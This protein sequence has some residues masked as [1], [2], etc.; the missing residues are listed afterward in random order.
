[1]MTYSRN[2]HAHSKCSSFTIP[3]LE[4]L[5]N[6]LDISILKDQRNKFYNMASKALLCIK[7]LGVILFL[8]FCYFVYTLLTKQFVCL[9]SRFND[10]IK[11]M[12][13]HKPNFFWQA[14]W[15]VIS[16]LIMFLILVFYIITKVSEE[17]LYKVWDPESVNM[18][19]F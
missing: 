15:R 6:H 2:I 18:N 12:I 13:G 14:S 8:C 16:P 17:L 9:Y 1:M 4:S 11:F 3:N 7:L 19:I 5:D 10:D